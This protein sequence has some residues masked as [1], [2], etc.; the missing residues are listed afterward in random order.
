MRRKRFKKNKNIHTDVYPLSGDGDAESC[1]VPV[2]KS[3]LN[4]HKEAYML[5]NPLIIQ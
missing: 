3:G 2:H 1:A 4:V 5:M